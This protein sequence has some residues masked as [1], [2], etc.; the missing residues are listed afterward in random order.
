MVVKTMRYQLVHYTR[1]RSTIICIV[2]LA[3]QLFDLI[4]VV[5]ICEGNLI[6]PTDVSLAT[7]INFQTME[8]LWF[9]T[10]FLGN[11]KHCLI[12]ICLLPVLIKKDSIHATIT[13]FRWCTLPTL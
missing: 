9:Y 4:L 2:E 8:M 12:T 11:I 13:Y 5:S 1:P 6:I 3:Y 10:I 7:F